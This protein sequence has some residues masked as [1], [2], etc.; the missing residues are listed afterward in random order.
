MVKILCAGEALVD[1]VVDSDGKIQGEHIGGSVFNVACGLAR[2]GMD[3]TLAS[4]WGADSRGASLE[5]GAASAGLKVFPGSNEAERTTVAMAYLDTAGAA[6]YQFDLLWDLPTGCSA[7]ALKTEGVG[8]LH[9]GSYSALIEP[10]ATKIA[11]LLDTK[12]QVPGLTVSYDP[13]MRPALVD[14]LGDTRMRVES[15]VT[16]CDLVKASDEDLEFLYPELDQGDVAAKWLE[17][18]LRLMVVTCGDDGAEL[19]APGCKEPLR[20]PRVTVPVADTVGAGDSFMA[21]LLTALSDRQALGS[22]AEPLTGLDAPK[23]HECLQFAARTAAVTVSHAG[24]YSPT[25]AE[26]A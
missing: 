12:A 14:D 16:C 3:T 4:W 5:S 21:G 23:L 11:A 6:T 2:L 1:V 26:I 24:A 10:G 22:G 19:Y 13:N 9:I 18:G 15:I 17:S 25:R 8:H 7:E 20:V